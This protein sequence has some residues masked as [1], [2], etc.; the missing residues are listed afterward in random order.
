MSFAL[1]TRGLRTTLVALATVGATLLASSGHAGYVARLWFE[2]VTKGTS[3]AGALL[4]D[5]G[6]QI[7]IKYYFRA[8]DQTGQTE[9]WGTMQITLILDGNGVMSE[10]DANTW[11]TQVNAAFVPG[12]WYPIKIFWQPDYGEM[13]D[14]AIDPSDPNY[15]FVANK[16]LY[17]LIGVQGTRTASYNFP[18]KTLFTFTIAPGSEGQTLNWA[19]DNR[20]TGTGLS[21]RIL[22]YVGASVDITDNYIQVTG[23]GGPMDTTTSVVAVP[24]P[25]TVGQNVSFTA[26]VS[27]TPDGGT[28][29]FKEDGVNLGA[30]VPVVGGQASTNKTYTTA[31]NRNIEAVFS[32]TSNFNPSTG[33]T[34][35]LV[36]KANTST[37]VNASPNPVDR[38]SNST[39]TATITPTPDGGT[40]Q[41]KENGVNLGAPVP[42]V[43]GQAQTTQQFNTAGNRTITA[44]YSGTA[45]YNASTG[46]TTLVVN[47]TPTST[48]VNA[49]PNPVDR[50]SN[51]TLTA[52]ITPTPDGGTVQFKENGVNLGGPVPVVAG[53]AQTTQQFNN[54]GNRTITAEYSGTTNYAASTGTTNLLVNKTPTGTTV[55]T[56]P[57]PSKVGQNVQ[58]TATVSPSPDG[59]T[60]Q[61]KVNGVNIGAPVSVVA[62]QAQTTYAF[63]AVGVQLVE[64]VYS[65][66][67]N[68]ESSAGS[69]DHTV[70]KTPTTT[71]V[72]AAPNPAQVGQQVTFTATITPTPDGGTV[73]FKV[74]G[75]NVGG[76][77]SV[78]AGQA[79]LQQTY[80]TP[81]SRFVEAVYSGTA[82]YEGS[83]GNT[84][85]QVNKAITTTTVTSTPNPSVVGQPVTLKATVTPTPDG[86]TVQFKVDGTDVGAP[87]AVVAGV[88]EYV[89]TFDSTG[90]KALTAVY[91]GTDNY[92]GSTG[93]ATHTVQ[94]AEAGLLNILC[95]PSVDDPFSGLPVTVFRPQV[96]NIDGITIRDVLIANGVDINDRLIVQAV[97]IKKVT[98][99]WKCTAF[100]TGPGSGLNT[101]FD[102]G[103][104]FANNQRL[105]DPI[106]NVAFQLPPDGPCLGNR[107]L[108]FSPPETL[109]ELTVVYVV[110]D[111]QGR[112]GPPQYATVEFKVRVSDREQIKCLIEYF[113]TVA[114][115]ATQ[116]PK[117]SEECRDALYRALDI[118]DDLDALIAF[119]TVVAQCS[120]DF[121][122]FL[123]KDTEGRYD[124]RWFRDYLIDSDEEP[125]GCL[126]VEMVNA[127]LW[128]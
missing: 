88:A 120:V 21:T 37:A 62:G 123:A 57:N 92:N 116:K 17:A 66:T 63:P 52:T 83:T 46:Q 44:E 40:V 72:V 18:A 82:G 9:K 71:T 28:V 3:N 38:G 16:G 20:D 89:H 93:T 90:V 48:A 67:S 13:R 35:L 80:A 84:T 91:S 95:G 117:I 45:N 119:E 121:P 74:D 61:F 126:L 100:V 5:P 107:A 96:L 29:Q 50:G 32:G 101:N 39:L 125:V 53:Q 19:F 59:G 24:N 98:P 58:I 111:D 42:V 94:T 14:N 128:K 79:T 12:A 115:G 26:T 25:A 54:A 81:G 114:V 105:N 110:L 97:R 27:P 68:F 69:A 124:V 11:A 87:V 60:V 23:G 6:D 4:C 10:A 103:L 55:S 76:P 78:V 41:F 65:G 77:V 109:Y 15:P 33:S 102:T 2:N 112:P 106:C 99:S 49:S 30:P 34:T 113:S 108:L 75:S 85:L 7:A 31:G 43:A 122:R 70:Q 51:S 104:K 47:K 56:S 1:S 36:N 118:Q 86:G 64:A 73:Q 127:L 22:D 8:D